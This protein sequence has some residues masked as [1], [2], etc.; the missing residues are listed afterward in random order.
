MKGEDSTGRRVLLARAFALSAGLASVAA[1]PG[2]VQAVGYGSHDFAS[3]AERAQGPTG[4]KYSNPGFGYDA[5]FGLCSDKQV[6]YPAWLEGEWEVSSTYRAKAFPLGE[7]YV[8]RSIRAGSARSAAEQIGDTTVF[9]ARYA[10]AETGGTLL[11][12]G[13][14]RTA[15]VSE[16][17]FN[18]AAMLNAYAGYKRVSK[19]EYDAAKDPT[20]MVMTYPSVGEDM[21]PLP[22][23]RTEVFINNRDFSLSADGRS[24]ASSEVF[25]AVTLGPAQEPPAALATPPRASGA[26]GVRSACGVRAR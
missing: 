15:V 13:K 8:Y 19:V 21:R 4:G 12:I 20:R 9:R 7:D 3:L 22:P 16:R 5:C 24:F 23:K 14:G 26:G 11:G 1:V 18:T 17:G 25:R 6:Y 10:A 2:E